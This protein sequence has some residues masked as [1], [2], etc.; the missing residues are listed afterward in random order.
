M[1]SHIG[2]PSASHRGLLFITLAAVSWGTVGIASKALYQ[3]SDTN[4][5]S[6]GFFRLAFAVPALW[7]ASWHILGAHALR[8]ARPDL[9]WMGLIGVAMALYQVFY[10]AAIAQVGVTIA[11]LVALCTAPVMVALLSSVL[12]R[13][14]ITR[15]VLMALAGALAG[16]TL[17]VGLPE[18][19]AA[20]RRTIMGVLLA[21]GAALS[22]SVVTICSRV[23]A[24]RYHP[25]QPITLGFGFG[26]MVLLP[27]ALATGLVV[28]YPV[29]GWALLLHLGLVPTALGYVLFLA[30][31]RH[32]TAT[33]A[34]IITLLEPLTSAVLAWLIFDERLGPLGL[35]G[36]MLLLGA[37]AM[38]YVSGRN[39]RSQQPTPNQ[40]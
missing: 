5:L 28:R 24:G 30:G 27:F 38:L 35:I 40:M 34:S 21:L 8:V 9:K 12:L 15:P 14:H 31:M 26:A 20:Q 22:Y 4:A 18:D 17:L 19:V 33:V 32:T 16:T 13:E 23:L 29:A 6:I 25:L 3:I 2:A 39:S 1:H 36:A 37:L 7:W 10:F 11:V